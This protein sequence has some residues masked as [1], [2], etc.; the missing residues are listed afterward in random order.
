MSQPTEP[1]TG[2]RS[3]S[4]AYGVCLIPLTFLDGPMISHFFFSLRLHLDGRQL[5][6]VIFLNMNKLGSSTVSLRPN[7][8][9]ILRSLSQH[10]L[11]GQMLDQCLSAAI[12]QENGCSSLFDAL[13]VLD[14]ESFSGEK[15]THSIA[16]RIGMVSMSYT[17]LIRTVVARGVA[18]ASLS[19]C[20]AFMLLYKDTLHPDAHGQTLL[21]DL[22][23]DYLAQ[24]EASIAE[25][26]DEQLEQDL[27][28]LRHR[29][30]GLMANGVE[31]SPTRSMMIPVMEVGRTCLLNCYLHSSNQ[32]LLPSLMW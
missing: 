24:A 20:E 27:V 3:S 5:P 22:L 10:S 14:S 12:C 4:I 31:I 7:E 19:R 28:G 17:R 11:N 13:P 26:L 18:T 2:S 16:E 8:F 6:P 23:V 1:Y 9:D 29:R 32:S 15:A 25:G 21:A 30:F